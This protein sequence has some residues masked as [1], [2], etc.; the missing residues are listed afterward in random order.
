[1]GAVGWVGDLGGLLEL[2]D[3]VILRAEVMGTH[4]RFPVYSDRNNGGTGNLGAVFVSGRFG[5]FATE[6]EG[7]RS[8][9]SPHGTPRP[10][11]WRTV[12]PSPQGGALPAPPE[13]P[14]PPEAVRRAAGA[15]CRPPA[16]FSPPPHFPSPPPRPWY[17]PDFPLAAAGPRPAASHLTPGQFP[18]ATALARPPNGRARALRRCAC[19]APCRPAPPFGCGQCAPLLG[20][21][22]PRFRVPILVS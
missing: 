9:G 22:E 1:M 20:G 21:A 17:T 13:A 5:H 4:P 16:P 15:R 2:N 12:L 10:T 18:R 19:A 7:R 11:A 6:S 8:V 3:S 14:P